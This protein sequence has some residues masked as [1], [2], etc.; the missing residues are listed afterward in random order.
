MSADIRKTISAA[1]QYLLTQ[2]RRD[3]AETKHE[4]VFPHR[5]GFGGQ[6]ERHFSDVFA[7]A[8][9]ACILMDIIDMD[10]EDEIGTATLRAIVRREADYV[11]QAKLTDRAGGWSY[12]PDLPDLPP[13]LDSLASVLRLFVRAAPAYI[14]LCREPLQIALDTLQ[15]HGALETWII[16]PGDRLEDQRRM[17]NGIKRFWGSGVHLDVCAHFFLALCEYDFGNYSD[18]IYR[19]ARY[20]CDR[21]DSNGSWEATWYGGSAYGAFLCL[22]LL[23]KLQYGTRVQQ[24]AIEFLLK[25][26][27]DDGGWGIWESVPLDTAVAIWA[28]LQQGSD[29]QLDVIGRA[30]A[31]LLDYQADDGRWNPSPWIKMDVGRAHAQTTHTLTYQSATLS[32][33]FCLR[34]LLLIYRGMVQ[35]KTSPFSNSPHL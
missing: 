13:D 26:Q 5:A 3:F 11:A 35:R 30:V 24:R 7:R 14:S 10:A 29:V 18:R 32:T 23:H 27:R 21:Q 28:L 33:A 17:R 31:C 8:V 6:K 16:A 1:K 20:I 34:S 15:S 25:S 19:G 22:S 4:M 12:F 2:A 9:L